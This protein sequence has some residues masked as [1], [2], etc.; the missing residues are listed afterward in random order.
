MTKN[1]EIK[2]KYALESLLNVMLQRSK[3]AADVNMPS[4]SPVAGSS[5]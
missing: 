3:S 4:P 1:S 2:I 5:T